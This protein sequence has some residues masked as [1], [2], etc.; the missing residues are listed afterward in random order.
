[1]TRLY[2]LL[3]YAYPAPV[4]QTFGPDMAE[5]FADLLREEQARGGLFAALS[6]LLRTLRDLPISAFAARLQEEGEAAGGSPGDNAEPATGSRR[7]PVDPR[8]GGRG[9]IDSV[10]HNLRY[11]ARSLLR[12]PAFAI[13]VVFTLAVGIG[14]NTVMFTV[15]DGI[16]LS[17]LPYEEPE[18]LVR[19]YAATPQRPDAKQFVPGSGF[20]AY[21]EQTDVFERLAAVYSYRQTG[22]DLTSGDE[23]Q[24][25]VMMP[26]SAGY[27]AVLG[28]EPMMGREFLPEEETG[29]TNVA[30][31]SY[32][33][34]QAAFA[35][36]PAILGRD[37]DL[38]G[39]PHTVVGV[40]PA[41]FRNPIGWDVD[42]WRP[43]NLQPGGRNSWSNYYLSAVGRLREGVTI[44][45]GQEKLKALG[46]SMY[47]EEPRTYE[48]YAAIYPL[49]D[50]TVG[51]TRT[52]LWVLM[53]A[54]GMVLLIACVNVASL[55]LVRSSERWKELAIR[56]ALGAGRRRLVG[57]MLTESVILGVAGGLGGLLLS[58]AGLQAV[59]AM[60]GDSLPR[61]AELGVDTGMLIFATAVSV[62][63]GLLFGIAPALR[64][65]RPNL[66]RTLRDDDRGH[67]GGKAQRRL[68]GALVVAEVSL[69]LVLLFGAGLLTKSFQQMV[70]VELG[71]DTGGVLTYEVHLPTSR[72]PEARDRIGFYDRFFARVEAIGGVEMI[73][74]TSYLPSEGRYHTW[75]L[76]REDLDLEDDNS[77]TGTDVRVVDGRYLELMGVQLVRGRMFDGTDSLETFENDRGA[78]LLNESWAALAFP[79][80]D[81]LGVEVT[82]GGDDFRVVGIVADTA[83]DPLGSTSPKVYTT[84]DQ[85]A[86][87]RNWAMIQTVRTTIEPAA[88]AGQLRAEL[89]T[90]DPQLVLYKVRTMDVVVARGIA[91]HRF[92]MTLM[93]GFAAIALLLAAVGIYGVLSYTVAQ[94]THEI[95]IRMALGADRAVVRGLVMRQGLLLAGLGLAFGTAGALTLTRWLSS[96]LF[97]V[98]PRDPLVLGG[99][100]LTLAL[101]AAFA[102][103]LPARRATSVDPIQALRKN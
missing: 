42:L 73:G 88:I 75:S 4:R 62:L 90:V 49:L 63:T 15:L 26:A 59:I 99:V 38:Q 25:I 64:F 44:E 24:R 80:R 10:A 102:G 60:T 47:E 56:A 40:M 67:S 85:F 91:P 12:S 11:S 55:F 53:G 32:G 84:H 66:E 46:V 79:D 87:D 19:L 68:R 86:G 48:T 29:D 1:M 31:I 74:A 17:P 58:I 9:I 50:D 30:V 3:L 52:M 72:Y 41:G 33:L 43:E 96:L 94:R 37:I 83:Y 93:T 18:R 35:G 23:T 65:S 89:R 97:E 69:A 13:V 27:F 81:P 92:S 71:V 78:V 45:Q 21:R 14:A 101:V 77:W 2:R 54:V 20:L 22:A 39:V 82:F 36:D 28:I 57:Q 61:V 51:E 7:P 76:G 100:A 98:Q 70:D 34:W 95:G 5:L 103:Y 6:V 8:R 16:L